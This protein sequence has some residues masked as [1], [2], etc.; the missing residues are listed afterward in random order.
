MGSASPFSSCFP[1]SFICPPVAQRQCGVIR[2]HVEMGCEAVLVVDISG[3][4]Q[5]LRL[6]V[7]N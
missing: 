5:K 3:E 1:C 6:G 2:L 4:W 7:E